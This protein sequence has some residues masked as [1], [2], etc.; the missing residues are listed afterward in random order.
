[1]NKKLAKIIL[2][3]G[4]FAVIGYSTI[5]YLNNKHTYV[6]P[7][8]IISEMLIDKRNYSIMVQDVKKQINI[9]NEAIT[10]KDYETLDNLFLKDCYGIPKSKRNSSIDS[11]LNKT[12]N[13]KFEYFTITINNG[14]EVGVSIGDNADVLVGDLISDLH[15]YCGMDTNLEYDNNGTYCVQIASFKDIDHAD[16]YADDIVHSGFED[17]IGS[18]IYTIQKPIKD[19]LWYAVR[20]GK[21]SDRE[22]AVAAKEIISMQLGVKDSFICQEK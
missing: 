19:V 4:A 17:N 6:K 14:Y 3:L 20:I 12:P 8:E 21:F 16:K 1:M 18:N 13:I 7:H 15:F 11:L 22:K 9:F 10:N 2:G 5:Y